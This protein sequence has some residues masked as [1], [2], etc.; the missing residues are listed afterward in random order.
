M[1]LLEYIKMSYLR[2]NKQILKGL[3]ASVELDDR[4]E[5]ASNTFGGE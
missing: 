4:G 1:N 5:I 2:P 3:G